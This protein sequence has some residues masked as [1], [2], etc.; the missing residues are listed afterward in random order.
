MFYLTLATLS[1][2]KSFLRPGVFLIKV[3]T[4]PNIARVRI[5]SAEKLYEEIFFM[6]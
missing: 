3:A 5:T 1:S 4:T 6:R 2:P